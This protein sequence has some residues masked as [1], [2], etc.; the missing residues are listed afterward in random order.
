MY[1]NEYYECMDHKELEKIQLERLKNTLGRVYHNVK[2]YRELM[3]QENL[4]PEDIDSLRDLAKLPFMKKQF[5]RD[6]YPYGLFATPMEEI[7]RI[8]SSSGTSGKP[9][10]V[11]YTRN[12]INNWSEMVAR[13][14]KMAGV[15]KTD[16]IHNSY[17][18]G[19]FTGGMG[20]HYGAE[21]LGASIVP[22]SGGNTG[23]Q[24]M[25]MKDYQCSVLTCTP[26]YALYLAEVMKKE[27]FTLKDSKLKY[28]IFGAEPW[29]ENMRTEIE[30][31]LGI[32]ALDIYGM[33][34]LMGPGVA[35][36]CSEKN[37]LH[38]AE[39][40]FIIE[41]INPNTGEVIPNGREG[42]IVFTSLTK[43]AFPIIRYRTGDISRV[44]T[45]KCACGRTHYRIARIEGRS[46]DM[47]IIRGVN[48]FP[49]Q[50]EHELL[51]FDGL[52]AHYQ[53]VVSREGVMDTL[54]VQVELSQERA[55]DDRAK[56]SLMSNQV[57]KKL[58]SS[59]GISVFVTLLEPETLERSQGKA[60]RTIDNR[61]RKIQ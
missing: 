44:Y 14:F 39:D 8:H 7:V 4:M 45:E 46:D 1:W 49:S 41:T 43:E 24:V 36:E 12:D 2:P 27:G 48:V 32:T 50:I 26:S 15:E 17:G 3:Q 59:L 47:L 20:I 10:V 60:K 53:L 57:R 23:R 33:S 58:E 34:E 30:E 16:I 9:T 42:E 56:L 35:M 19:L 5:L 37:G 31:K 11:G 38:V 18:Y 40:H 21:K 6:N 61:H 54:E 25:L 55:L 13:S 52:E 51:S 29:S 22:V 28:G